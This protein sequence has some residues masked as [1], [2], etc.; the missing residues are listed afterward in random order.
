M[1]VPGA[2]GVQAAAESKPDFHS[3]Y[4]HGIGWPF[5]YR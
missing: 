3:P 1:H 4:G 5:E 2:Q